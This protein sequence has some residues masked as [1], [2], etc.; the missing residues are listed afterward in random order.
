MHFWK[1]DFSFAFCKSFKFRY[2]V[3]L[4]KAQ[5]PFMYIVYSGRGTF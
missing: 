3:L 4:Y 2:V 1:A 5:A